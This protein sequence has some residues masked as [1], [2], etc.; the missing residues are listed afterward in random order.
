MVA[1]I[2]Q[3]KSL[4][5]ALNYNEIK[6]QKDKA[7]LID[8]NGYFKDL[9]DLNF[10]DKLFRLT[11]LADRNQRTKTNAVHISL[12][13]ANGEELKTDKLQSIIAD[14]MEQIG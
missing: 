5:G 9:T 6:V 2:K 12:N 14:Y 8:V 11:D 3:G 4:I 7:Q 13:F 1:K 10:Y